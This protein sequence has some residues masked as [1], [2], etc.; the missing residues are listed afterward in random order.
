MAKLSSADASAQEGDSGGEKSA[1]GKASAAKPNPVLLACQALRNSLLNLRIGTAEKSEEKL[2]ALRKPVVA[3]A[4]TLALDK[5]IVLNPLAVANLPPI[6]QL[7]LELRKLETGVAS[8]R[9]RDDRAIVSRSD[10]AFLEFPAT[11]TVAF[12][13][14]LGQRSDGAYLTIEP[15]YRLGNLGAFEFT[16]TRLEKQVKAF[17]MTLL[18]ANNQL[19]GLRNDVPILQRRVSIAQNIPIP[20]GANAAPARFA[21][22]QQIAKAQG[23]LNKTL[24]KIAN[25]EQQ[26]PFTTQ[27]LEA[28]RPITQL[29]AELDGKAK[30]HYR[31]YEVLDYAGVELQLDL[32]HAGD[33]AE[34]KNGG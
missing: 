17:Q 14:A 2:V 1:A 9:F 20:S 16:M 4:L 12:E 24:K 18:T 6:G 21:R 22:E 30:L 3:P 26:I 13:L 34:R 10:E 11:P 32:L 19:P 15:G 29:A 28:L 5:K 31:L 33:V 7:R 25:L 8:S 23:N 27:A